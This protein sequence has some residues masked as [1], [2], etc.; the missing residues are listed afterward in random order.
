VSEYEL[1]E[2]DIEEKVS[3][4]FAKISDPVLADLRLEI[5]GA[6]W[7]RHRYPKDLP[8]LFRGDQLVV[9]GAYRRAGKDGV[10]KLTG[11]M[12]GV[13]RSFVLPVTLGAGKEHAFLAKLWA[14][15]RVGYLLDQIRLHGENGEL[16]DEVVQLARKHGIVTPY[17]SYLIVEDE[18]RR[19]VPVPMRTQHP[20]PEAASPGGSAVSGGVVAR[21][22]DAFRSKTE[23][24]DAVA[25]AQA[26]KVLKEGKGST[27][28]VDAANRYADAA[29]GSRLDLGENRTVAGKTFYRN[30]LN[31][32]DQ[33]AQALPAS[34]PRRQV[35]FASTEYFDLLASRPDLGPWLSVGTGV[36]VAIGAELIEI[37]P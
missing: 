15:R 13:E 31:W 10:V 11:T 22:Y 37:L 2:E 16:K 33:E 23:G 21:E 6:E 28:A 20:V 14:T 19:G 29:R 3:R 17:T 34:A 7:I 1:P 30:G 9:L 36:Q 24:A 27:S 12:A 18:E 35:K 26:A 32:I 8:D 4:F 5:D 25:A